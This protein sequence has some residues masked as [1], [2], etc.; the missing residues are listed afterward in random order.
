MKENGT[1]KKDR[2]P[3]GR[4]EG[5]G[6]GDGKAAQGESTGLNPDGSLLEVRGLKT[7]FYTEEGVIPAVN[8]VSFSLMPRE[9]LGLVG[10]SGCGKSVTSLS[11]MGLI[12]CPPGKIVGGQILYRGR[13]LASLREEEMRKVRGNEIAM[14]FQEP[15]TALN[16]V[17]TVGQQINEV[18]ELHT[19][20]DKKARRN[21]VVE[22]LSLVGIPVPEKRADAYPHELSGGMRQRVMIAMALACN[23]SLIVAD[24]PTTALDVT[25]QAQILDLLKDLQRRLGTAVILIT[26]NLAVIAETVERVAVMYAG[27]IVEL[28]EVH[29]LFK[30]CLHPYTERLLNSI[31]ILG[32]KTKKLVPIMGRVPN[33]TQL[34]PGCY[35]STRCPYVTP[36]CRAEH[37]TLSEVAPGH[38]V[39]CFLRRKGPD[40]DE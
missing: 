5:G 1:F 6:P 13:D 19:S 3:D 15:M 17:Y 7:W 11:I 20:L 12:E 22:L 8:D 37:P 25:I 36:R 40:T 32:N 4:V 28:A 18:L 26:H 35:F 10:E 9:T 27:V 23:P 29:T 33:L 14:I 38:L 21:R 16:P 31:P 2:T 30:S 34:P 24:E 39:R